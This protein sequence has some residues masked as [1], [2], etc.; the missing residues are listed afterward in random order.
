[1]DLLISREG[2]KCKLW[3]VVCEQTYGSVNF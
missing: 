1:M 2:S 3:S